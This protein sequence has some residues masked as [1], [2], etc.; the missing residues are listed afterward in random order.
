[1]R[2]LII[3]DIHANWTA[4]QQVQEEHDACFFLGDLVDY[5][6]EPI[7]CIEWVQQHA[8]YAVRGN[9]DHAVAQ[10]AATNGRNGFKYLSGATRELTWQVLGEDHLRFLGSLPVTRRVTL[11]GV[12]FLLVHATPRDPL[13]EYA[14][15]DPTFWSRRL[16]GVDAD[17]VCVGHTHL[18]YTLR[19][20]GKTVI[21]PGSIGQPRDGDPRAAYAVWEDG[22]VELKRVAYPI[23]EV[24]QQFKD[25]SLPELARRL[26][27]QVFRTGASVPLE[28]A[29]LLAQLPPSH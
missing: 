10:R 8:D 3:A 25:S 29:R 12:R 2:I 15:G 13:E 18:P 19:V 27:I 7:P 23:E 4:L 28:T 21:N 24:V 1:M 5:G 16:Q 22:R 14:T 26:S 11:G 17:V 6:L 20:D 9:H